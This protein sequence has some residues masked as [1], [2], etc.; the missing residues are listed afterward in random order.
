MIKINFISLFIILLII[1]KSG[2]SNERLLFEGNLFTGYS[3]VDYSGES[4]LAIYAGNVIIRQPNEKE[5]FKI[6]DELNLDALLTYPIW[7]KSDSS[8]YINVEDAQVKKDLILEYKLNSGKV[9]TLL[10]LDWDV[11]ISSYLSIDRKKNIYFYSN[12]TETENFSGIKKLN[13]TTGKVQHH[14]SIDYRSTHQDG[15]TLSP[16]EKFF[17]MEGDISNT[18]E[19]S[20]FLI[21]NT[22][23]ITPIKPIRITQGGFDLMGGWSSDSQKIV[24][25]RLNQYEEGFS[26]IYVYSLDTKKVEQVTF[27]DSTLNMFPIFSRNNDRIIFGRNYMPYEDIYTFGLLFE[28][29]K[30]GIDLS[31]ETINDLE[32]MALGQTSFEIWEVDL[33]F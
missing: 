9:D 14:I 21:P 10:M 22:K 27:T 19:R 33:T 13:P 24:F 20:L 32:S 5:E 31:I 8:I 6:L 7:S 18:D 29:T 28:K 12:K 15:Y 25:T 4:L 16:D 2:T 3:Q 17:L 30:N 23:S 11:Y 1:Y 26:D